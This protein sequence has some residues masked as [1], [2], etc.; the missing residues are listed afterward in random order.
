MDTAALF[1]ERLRHLILERY[2]SLDRFYLESGVSKGHLSEILRGVSSP[3]VAT[4]IKLAEALEVEV[5]DFFVFP[6]ENRRHQAM[7]LLEDCPEETLAMIL[8]QLTKSAK[9]TAK[10]K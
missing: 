9:T 7:V 8:R 5:K 4:L 10:T 3:S 2:P 6:E 1:R